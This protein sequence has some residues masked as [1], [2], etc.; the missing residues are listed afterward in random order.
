MNQ[1]SFNAAKNQS[2]QPNDGL[3]APS[4]TRR[5][6]LGGGLF[7]SLAALAGVAGGLSGCAGPKIS[8]PGPTQANTSPVVPYIAP[9]LPTRPVPQ[10]AAG[11]TISVI[12][13][14]AWTRTGPVPG[15][16][17][18]PMHGV[19][20][21]TVHHEGMGAFTSTSESAVAGR[22]ESIR[23]AHLRRK[24]KTGERWADIGY[25]YLI[26]PAGRVWEGR[27]VKWQGAH[28][29]DENE[30]NLGV[31]V[32][33]NFDVQKPSSQSLA[34][35][36]AFVAQQMRRYGVS[37]SRVLTHREIGATACPGSSL[38]SYMVKTRGRGGRLAI[39]ALE[40]GLA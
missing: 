30:H 39:T 10:Q 16:K 31:M 37:R 24:A 15:S 6:V 7:V 32:L 34:T 3:V 13:R 14:S 28:V 1:N 20:R 11:G 25:H 17:I 21:I 27:N 2:N 35:L 5:E 26:D 4:L 19:T 18:N 9:P 38:Q 12:P 22:I 29:Q 33:G 36:D 8:A 40:M 23:Q